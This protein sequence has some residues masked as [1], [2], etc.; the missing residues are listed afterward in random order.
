MNQAL[1]NGRKMAPDKQEVADFSCFFAL[2]A[3][4]ADWAVNCSIA[5]LESCPSDHNVRT[6]VAN[7][8]MAL[9]RAVLS[10]K[11]ETLISL[12]RYQQST[13]K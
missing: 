7:S 9:L 13:D 8:R 11:S 5:R 3:V 2:L 6:F 12:H 1:D 10:G 4:L